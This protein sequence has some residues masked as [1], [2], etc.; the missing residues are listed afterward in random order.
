MLCLSHLRRKRRCISCPFE[1]SEAS[2][3]TVTNLLGEPE[4][5]RHL[6]GREPSAVD[7][8]GVD[9]RR[10]AVAF[11]EILKIVPLTWGALYR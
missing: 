5:G 4:S 3:V 1:M 10:A 2:R 9:S 11:M 6:S 8:D 7:A